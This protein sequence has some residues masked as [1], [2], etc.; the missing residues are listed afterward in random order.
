MTMKILRNDLKVEKGGKTLLLR[1]Y[2]GIDRYGSVEVVELPV[3]GLM[4]WNDDVNAL[5][6][7]VYDKVF[8]SYPADDGVVNDQYLLAWVEDG[9]FTS[10]DEPFLVTFLKVEVKNFDK[11]SFLKEYRKYNDPCKRFEE[12]DDPEMFFGPGDD[13]EI[14]EYNGYGGTTVIRAEG[15]EGLKRTLE[16]VVVE[17]GMFVEEVTDFELLAAAASAAFDAYVFLAYGV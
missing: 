17:D 13:Y 9:Y 2:S 16:E 11:S 1:T 3:I 7:R 10:A 5:L 8:L 15:L 6:D 4:S 12:I 14:I